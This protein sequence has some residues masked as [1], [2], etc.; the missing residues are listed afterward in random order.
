MTE[1]I[2]ADFTVISREEQPAEGFSGQLSH[3]IFDKTF[4]GDLEGTSVVQLIAIKTP[5]ENAMA[6][7]AFEHIT[8]TIG[9]RKGTFVVR[10]SALMTPAE[11]RSGEWIVV[12][13]AGDGDFAA[14]TGRGEIV[15]GPS[16]EVFQLDCDFGD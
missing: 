5:V 16:G 15:Q 8:G 10:H 12:P 2:N 6:Y 11:G 7:V 13:H 14:L 4:T 9:D 3:T 1:R